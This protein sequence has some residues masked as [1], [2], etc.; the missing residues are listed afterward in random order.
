MARISKVLPSVQRI[1]AHD[2]ADQVECEW[3][4]VEDAD[5]TRLLHLSTFGS[6]N[7]ASKRKSSQS[8][9]FDARIA[10][11]L[12]GILVEAFGLDPT[13]LRDSFSEQTDPATVS[14][15]TPALP[16]PEV[17]P[18][19]LSDE[20]ANGVP[21]MDHPLVV[22]LL[23]SETFADQR[24]LAGR[25][26]VPDAKIGLLVGALLNTRFREIT[27]TQAAAVLAVPATRVQGALTQVKNVLDVEG[28]EV[29]ILDND[30]VRLVEGAMVEQFGLT[31]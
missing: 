9:Q 2:P 1:R 4:V 17:D 26:S 12:A 20:V 13:A 19:V 29:L 5:G 24:R 28:Y 8:I 22:A 25:V 30:V 3:K 21:A 16:V 23:I 14:E 10:H 15:A 6:S 7:R 27:R 31:R 11:E 18:A